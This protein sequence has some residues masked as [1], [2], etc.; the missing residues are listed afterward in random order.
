MFYQHPVW[1]LIAVLAG[2]ALISSRGLL[3]AI[4][5]PGSSC[6]FSRRSRQSLIQIV[7]Y[8]WGWRMGAIDGHCSLI[9]AEEWLTF[10]NYIFITTLNDEFPQIPRDKVGDADR[11][12][13]RRFQCWVILFWPNA[14]F[15]NHYWTSRRTEEASVLMWTST[16]N[17]VCSTSTDFYLLLATRTNFK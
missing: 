11:P 6:L 13:V 14:F 4:T 2:P 5:A 7:S 16:K 17:C 1:L 10:I 9:I 12:M 15:M 8:G 3:F